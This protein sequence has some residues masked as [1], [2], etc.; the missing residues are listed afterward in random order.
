MGV[1]RSPVPPADKA[2]KVA[3]DAEKVAKEAKIAPKTAVPEKPSLVDP[4]GQKHILEGDGPGKGGGHRPG[5][6]KPGKSEFREGWSD[7]KILGE[8]SDIATDPAIRWTRPDARGYIS[9]TKTVDGVDI[10]VVVDTLNGRIVTGFPTN[11]PRN[12]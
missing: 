11:L 9:G 3:Q 1:K 7:G 12:Q 10:K 4:K 6:G 2:A 8:V 5:T